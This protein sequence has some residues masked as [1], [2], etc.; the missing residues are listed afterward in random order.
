MNRR[1]FLFSSLA[2][3]ATLTLS[4]S[5]QAATDVAATPKPEVC[6]MKADELTTE[7]TGFTRYEHF[8]QLTIPVSILV[9]PPTEG[10]KIRTTPL[11]QGSLDEVA[12]AAF[13]KETGIDASLRFHSHEVSF[14]AE[15]LERIASGEK[16]VK[17]S[18]LSPKGNPAHD[19][20]FSASRSV[21]IKVN[22][23]RGTKA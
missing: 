11:D 12:F 6:V 23:G 10:F 15:E 17:I 5:S 22:R 8:H 21:I 3:G 18:V 7:A 9:K 4:R 20:F 2:T 14:T 1:L 13:I 19:F 16:A